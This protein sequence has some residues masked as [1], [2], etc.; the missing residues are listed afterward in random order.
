MND[1]LRDQ[2]PWT[3]RR[4]YRVKFGFHDGQVALIDPTDLM[5]STVVLIFTDSLSSGAA[6][7]ELAT[8]S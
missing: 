4:V 6:C 7:V 2:S 8:A 1:V 3:K 5:N